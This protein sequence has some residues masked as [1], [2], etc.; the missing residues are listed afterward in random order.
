MTQPIKCV[1]L[2]A[3][4]NTRAQPSANAVD[5]GNFN[6]NEEAVCF[7]EKTFVKKADLPNKEIWRLVL[8]ADG[9][10]GWAAEWHPTIKNAAGQQYAAIVDLAPPAPP[11]PTVLLQAIGDVNLR[12]YSETN[13]QGH[14]LMKLPPVGSRPKFSDGAQ[15]VASPTLVNADGTVD[16]YQVLNGH[17]ATPAAY[18]PPAGHTGWFVSETDIIQL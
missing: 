18:P 4:I 5:T 15:I 6:K 1:T 12:Y 11:I 7:P 10:V 3:Y 9:T 8:K 2:G 16:Y 14:P 17:L 13:A